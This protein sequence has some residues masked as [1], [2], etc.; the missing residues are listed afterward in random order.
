[1]HHT[2]KK[3]ALSVKHAV[4]GLVW[5]FQTQANYR[6]HFAFSLLSLFGSYVFHVS[7]EEF[8]VILTLIFIGFC[9]ETINTAIEE[10][11]DAID[12]EYREDIKHAKDVAAAAMLV[13][14]L[15]AAVIAA[16]IFVPKII[17][18]LGVRI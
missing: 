9:I 17:A 18:I 5:A 10:T 15:G 4:A 2:I 13:F 14:A 6:I 1:M 12:T 8:L 16:I 11:T 3:H 7:Y